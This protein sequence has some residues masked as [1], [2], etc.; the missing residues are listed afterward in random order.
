MSRIDVYQDQVLQ[1]VVDHLRD[2]LGLD[3]NQVYMTIDPL[4]PIIPKGGDYW[5]SVSPGDGRFDLALAESTVVDQ[6]YEDSVVSVYGYT[7][8]YLDESNTDQQ[9][10]VNA[11]RGILVVKRLILKSMSGV[12]LSINGQLYGRGLLTPDYATSPD[13][14]KINREGEAALPIGIVGINFKAPFDW[15]L[16]T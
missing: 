9:M 3:E 10:L 2:D 16:N 11:T 6:C 4:N 12:D 1:A 8:I 5:L 13:V 7:R 14:G 15:D